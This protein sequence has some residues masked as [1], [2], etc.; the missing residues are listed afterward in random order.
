CKKLKV[1]L[2]YANLTKTEEVGYGWE[3]SVEGP[4]TIELPSAASFLDSDRLPFND[5]QQN[6]RC[7]VLKDIKGSVNE[8]HG[9]NGEKKQKQEEN[10]QFAL[11]ACVYQFVCVC[12][13]SIISCRLVSP[14]NDL[15]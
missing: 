7:F 12:W 15:T 2:L 14:P 11:D 9:D 10:V 6:L 4:C 13:L 3:R 8:M 5:S 1:H